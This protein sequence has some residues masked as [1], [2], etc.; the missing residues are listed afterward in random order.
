MCVCVCLRWWLGEAAEGQGWHS[1]TIKGQLCL[2]GSGQSQRPAWAPWS[3]HWVWVIDMDWDGGGKGCQEFL[4]LGRK[5]TL[6][7]ETKLPL[8]SLHAQAFCQG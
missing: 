4:K 8:A 5:R 2:I 1:H 7:S 6:L 3:E